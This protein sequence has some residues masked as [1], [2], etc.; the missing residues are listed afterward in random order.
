MGMSFNVAFN[1]KVPPYDTQ[2]ADYTTLGS[3]IEKLDKIASK[4]GLPTLGQ[5]QFVDIEEM[6]ELFGLDSS[7]IGLPAKQWHPAADGIAAVQG[8]IALLRS[9]PKVIPK[10]AAILVELE[11]VEQE[12]IAAQSRK[13]KFHFCVLD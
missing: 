8:M 10:S 6:A 4:R 5:F 13:A 1:K 9:E 12:L 11:A 2:G 7:E 3:S